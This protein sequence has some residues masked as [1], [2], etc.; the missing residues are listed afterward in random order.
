MELLVTVTSLPAPMTAIP[1][2]ATDIVA[3]WVLIELSRMV[4]SSTTTSAPPVTRSPP[5]ARVSPLS[6]P[7]LG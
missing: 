3:F 4:V 1:P 7:L 2:P 6:A 5:P